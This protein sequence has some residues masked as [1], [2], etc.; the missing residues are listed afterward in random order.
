M[1]L[2]VGGLL[3]LIILA[4]DIWAIVKILGSGAGAGAKALW[5][6]LI[7]VLPVVGLLL[8]LALGPKAP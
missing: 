1:G 4:L 2:E 8:W 5:I 6:V 3:G 7:L